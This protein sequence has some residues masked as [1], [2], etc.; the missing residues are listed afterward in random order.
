MSASET[1]SLLL[2]IQFCDDLQDG[3]KWITVDMLPTVLNNLCV[4]RA[5]ALR[6]VESLPMNTSATTTASTAVSNIAAAAASSSRTSYVFPI[7]IRVWDPVNPKCGEAVVSIDISA[8][9]LSWPKC[10]ESAPGSPHEDASPTSSAKER[11]LS[12]PSKV[13]RSLSSQQDVIQQ[14]TPEGDFIVYTSLREL[15]AVQGEACFQHLIMRIPDKD[16]VG[17]GFIELIPLGGHRPE[18]RFTVLPPS[19]QM[20]IT[21]DGVI[22]SKEGNLGRIYGNNNSSGNAPYLRIDL[23]GYWFEGSKK[24][25]YNANKQDLIAPPGI[26]PSNGSGRITISGGIAWSKQVSGRVSGKRLTTLLRSIY[27][28]T[29]TPDGVGASSLVGTRRFVLNVS[30]GKY[31]A[32]GRLEV[33]SVPLVI[34]VTDG[35][36]PKF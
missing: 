18:D 32:F 15:T 2:S 7:H 5:D 3:E 17:G 8:P 19:N 33:T 30:D 26:D 11:R 1:A 29:E 31:D 13:S 25:S 4:E 14:F 6:L 21:T 12:L 24:L 23:A 35:P 28:R 22:T 36:L 34:Q 27:F 9:M 20:V 10:T 16:R